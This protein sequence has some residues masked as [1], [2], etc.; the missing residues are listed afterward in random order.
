MVFV[1][2]IIIIYYAYK[3][4]LPTKLFSYIINTMVKDFSSA[5]NAEPSGD[6]AIFFKELI[7]FYSK[8][9]LTNFPVIKFT[10]EE[11]QN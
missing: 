10:T 7:S 1:W 4:I 8:D 3:I 6:F 2:Q 9:N 11:T 5:V